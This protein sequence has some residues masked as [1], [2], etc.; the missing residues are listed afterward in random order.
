MLELQA[1]GRRTVMC[2]TPIDD[3][4]VLAA[5]PETLAAAIDELRMADRSRVRRDQAVASALQSIGSDRVAGL[6]DVDL[7]PLFERVASAFGGSAATLDLSQLPRRHIGCLELR[8]HDD[9]TTIRCSV[10]SSR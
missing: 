3:L 1:R 9:G 7:T 10:L 8:P 4:I 5:D 2:V 6:F